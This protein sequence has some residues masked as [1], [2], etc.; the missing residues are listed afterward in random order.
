MKNVLSAFRRGESSGGLALIA[1]AIAGLV[2]ANSPLAQSYGDLL[3]LKL[4]FST[5]I[6]GIHL[7]AHDWVN[8]GLMAVFFLIVGLEI[9]REVLD[10]ELSTFGR[11]ALGGILLPSIV[12][13]PPTWCFRRCSPGSPAWRRSPS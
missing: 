8:D 11:A 9:K 4:G 6:Y 10:G 5:D 12:S 3:H 7:T 13:T 1:G 2:W